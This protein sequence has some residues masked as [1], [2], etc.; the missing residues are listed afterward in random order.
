MAE[1]FAFKVAQRIRELRLAQG[2]SLRQLSARAGM[3][4][5]SVSRA[6]RGLHEVTLTNLDKITRGLGVTLSAFFDFQTKPEPS[7]DAA[8]A[9]DLAR[10]TNLL[11]HTGP[12]VRTQLVD[13]LTVMCRPTTKMPGRRPKPRP[14]RIR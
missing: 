11:R 13:V 1:E 10:V 5:E 12:E 2:L 4:P 3:A 8:T 7:K 14:S 6:E 9:A